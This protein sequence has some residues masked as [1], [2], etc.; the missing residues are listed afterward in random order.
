MLTYFIWGEDI[1]S[2]SS[3]PLCA[4]ISHSLTKQNP[5]FQNWQKK[6]SL[7]H[8]PRVEGHPRTI[9]MSWIQRSWRFVDSSNGHHSIACWIPPPI[10]FQGHL[11]NPYPGHKME[12]M[13]QKW[14]PASNTS[15]FRYFPYGNASQMFTIKEFPK[16]TLCEKISHYLLSKNLVSKIDLKKD[17]LSMELE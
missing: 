15:F 6:W 12:T 5:S 1:Q 10:G 2:P 8:G 9:S 3:W 14:V 17:P 4:K 13:H 11:L 16:L 7:V